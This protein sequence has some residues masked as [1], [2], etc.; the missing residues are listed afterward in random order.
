MTP[1]PWSFTFE[2]L[3]LALA[4]LAGAVYWRSARREPGGVPRL[5]ALA[6][7]TGLFL[8]AASTNSPLETLSA[9]YLLLAHLLQNVIISDWAPPLLVLGLTPRMR[10]QIAAR[11]G[12]VLRALTRL[13]VAL[14]VWLLGWY[15]IHLAAFYDAA[16]ENT[17]LL[18]LEHAILILIGLVF[19]WPVFSQAPRAHGVLKRLAYVAAGFFTSVFLGLALTFSGS[20]FYDFY[21][22]AP[23]L[24]GL[25]PEEDQ[26]YAGVLMTAEQAL[27]FLAAITWLLLQLFR[28]EDAKERADRERLR[29]AGLVPRED[30]EH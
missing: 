20:A 10:E 6:F 4:V 15:L 7:G 19:W 1:S 2:P 21:E 14:P 27:I 26:N 9:H 22:D 8:I 11:G 18:H 28:E 16:L 23:R 13:R 3:F 12:A 24:W 30:A 17:Y 25:S 5:R 29:A